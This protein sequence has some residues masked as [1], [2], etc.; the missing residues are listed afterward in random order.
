MRSE[1]LS[2]EVKQSILRLKKKKSTR[3]TA[4]CYVLRKNERTGE[5]ENSKRS[6]HPWRT[7]VVDDHRI[8]PM[9]KKKPF[10]AS[11]QVKNPLQEEGVSVSRSTS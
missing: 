3:E 11:T 4:V 5:L 2:M 9:V 6:G 7:T 1:K 10:T 8:L